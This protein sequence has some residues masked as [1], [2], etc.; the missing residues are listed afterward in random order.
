VFVPSY[1]FGTVTVGAETSLELG[2]NSIGPYCE[3]RRTTTGLDLVNSS[4]KPWLM[5]YNL[6]LEL[7]RAL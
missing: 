4:T 3:A 7:E 6:L 1:V 2:F 5:L